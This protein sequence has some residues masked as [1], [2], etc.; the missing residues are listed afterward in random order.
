MMVANLL[1]FNTLKKE[2]AEK[3]TD[4]IPGTEDRSQSKTETIHHQLQFIKRILDNE[5]IQTAEELVRNCI[6]TTTEL[7]R[8]QGYGTVLAAESLYISKTKADPDLTAESLSRACS[9]DRWRRIKYIGSLRIWLI[10][11]LLLAHEFPCIRK[12]RHSG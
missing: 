1:D 4:A 2:E 11:Q 5:K 3:I 6:Y 7:R 8:S 12:I 9:Q 10:N